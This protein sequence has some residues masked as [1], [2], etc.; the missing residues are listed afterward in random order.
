LAWLI[1]IGCSNAGELS[2][3]L[4]CQLGAA[5]SL[6]FAIGP[7]LISKDIYSYVAQGL[8]LRSGH[9]VYRSGVSVLSSVHTSSAAHALAAVDP[10]WRHVPSPYG[11]LA[12]ALERVSV[13][14][15]GGNPL[16]AVLVLR[17]VAVLCVVAIAYLASTMAAPHRAHGLVLVALNPLVLIHLV[18]AN[19]LE[20]LMGALILTSLVAANRGQWSWAIVSA[21]AAGE[22]KAPAFATLAVLVVV[23]AGHGTRRRPAWLRSVGRIVLTDLVVATVTCLALTALVPDGFGWVRNL[24]TPGL[25]RTAASLS[26]AAGSILSSVL[27]ATAGDAS[28]AACRTGGLAVAA[29][30]V[31]Y[32]VMTARSRPT[33][34]SVGFS[35]LTLAFLGPVFYPW[36]VLWGALCLLPTAAPPRRDWLVALCSVSSVAAITGVPRAIGVGMTIAAAMIAGSTLIVRT[37]RRRETAVPAGQTPGSSHLIM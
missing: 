34:A 1:V 18:S 37:A 24:S 23:H 28:V 29:A 25:S 31:L 5:W 9:D 7:P 3:R 14:I 33:E 19:H 16:G 26:S 22:V 12:S 30:I 6:P 20:A 8:M 4:V 21:C 36:Y 13:V 10:T 32:L 27:P 2:P 15:S 35:L 11:P 17:A